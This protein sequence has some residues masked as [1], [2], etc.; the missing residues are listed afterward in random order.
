MASELISSNG[1]VVD[2]S[3]I[4]RLEGHLRGILVRPGDDSYDDARRLWNGSFDKRPALIARCNCA[5]DVLH[6]VEFARSHDLIPTIRAGGHSL[7]GKSVSDGGLTIDVSPMKRIRVDRKE[8]VAYAEAGLLLGEFDQATVL[9]GLATT[10]GTA[11]DTGIA[12]LVLGGG[13]GWLMSRNGLA[14][15]NLL[16]VE[17][18]TADGRIVR[19]SA[20]DNPDLF[21]GMRGAGTNFGVVTSFKFRLHPISAVL[22]GTISYPI[23]DAGSVLRHVHELLELMPDELTILASGGILAGEPS[24]SITVCWSGDLAAGE[25]A[26]KPLRLLGRVLRDSV[27]PIPYQAMQAMLAMPAGLKGYWK[28]G[29]LHELNPESIEPIVAHMQ[30]APSATSGWFVFSLH[31]AVCQPSPT[32]CAFAHR[33][34]GWDFACASLWEDSVMAEPSTSWVRSFWD[35]IEPSC[36]GVYVNTVMDEGAARVRAAY[37]PN[38]DRLV[39]LKN[40]YDPTNFFRMNQNIEPSV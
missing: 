31:G 29:V 4:G 12:G 9:H 8:R 36:S 22:G 35:A 18:V 27:V 13:L 39:A 1:R 33:A 16:E 21:W 10:M 2:K 14:C 23:S 30:N 19:A 6:A 28:S 38:Y 11:P 24:L 3:A 25:E 7:S 26:L 32:D 40:K 37:G 34:P 17:A 20:Q 15:D 5:A